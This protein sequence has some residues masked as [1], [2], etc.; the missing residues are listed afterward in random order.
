MKVNKQ[1]EAILRFYCAITNQEFDYV[2]QEY[3]GKGIQTNNKLY[4][5]VEATIHMLEETR[6]YVEEK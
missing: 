3:L 2:V 6:G 1:R 5:N 4:T